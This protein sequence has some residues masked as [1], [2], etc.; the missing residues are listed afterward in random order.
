MKKSE[1]TQLTQ[2]I[3]QLVKKEVRKQLPVLIEETFQNMTGKST[4]N[5]NQN[6]EP[7]VKEQVEELEITEDPIDF[8]ASLRELFAGTPVMRNPELT[9]PQTKQI[10]QYTKDPKLNAILNETISDLRDKERLV[11]AAAMAGGYSPSLN[12]IPG[13]NP[14]AESMREMPAE[15]SSMKNM[16]VMRPPTPIDGQESTHAPLSALPEGISA[17]DLARH[18]AIEKPEIKRAL[19][20][21][22]SEMMKIID[23]KKGKV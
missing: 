9:S 5:N 16:P 19:T 1:F 18:G 14:S 23:K 4:I 6:R 3:E 17:I 20:R 8:K 22:Y 10:K 11:G 21:N 7:V 15:P 2:I 13:F 12:M